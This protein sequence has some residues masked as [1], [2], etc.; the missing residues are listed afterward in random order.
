MAE[1]RPN[2]SPFLAGNYAPVAEEQTLT[3]L[4]VIGSIPES[5]DGRFIRNGPNPLDEPDPSTYHWFTGNG[6]V[7]GVR[8][9]DGRAE[10]Y[11]NRIVRGPAATEFL[12]EDP[13]PGPEHEMFRGGANTNV[14]GHAGATWAIVEAGGYPFRLNDELD[15]EAADPFGGTLDGP[16]T[17]HP[18]RDPDTGELH[19]I[20]Y[21]PF[22]GEIV[23]YVVVGVDG[24]VRKTVDVPVGG[25]PMVHDCGLTES[26]VIVLDL[27]CVFDMDLAM[28]GRFPFSWSD[29]YPARMG[30]LDR[31]AD[32]GN[33]VAWFDVDPCYV[34]HPLN[35]YDLPDGG[36]VLDAV[37]HPKV[38]ASNLNGPNEGGPTLRR[39]T[40]DPSSGKATEELLDDRP[41]EFPR[42]DERILGKPHRFGYGAA[43]IP[44]ETGVAHGDAV[45]HDLVGG[46]SE[47]HDYGEGRKTLEPVFVPTSDGS[48]ED[49]GYVMSYVY[50]ATTD[51][52]DIVILHAQDFTGEPVAT[53]KLPIRVP[54][55]FHGNWVPTGQ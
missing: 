4:E 43:F 23:H 46:T 2:P 1:L 51:T 24:K 15:T 41:Q 8:L 29:D 13:V 31:E 28:Q 20:C 21:S 53:V 54:Y 9:R 35:A 55:G 18:K 11:R 45:K 39:W 27:P 14:I 52:S 48:A 17:A 42:M 3:D 40:F 36:V 33:D 10:W 16:F 38:F 22:I 44:D 47:V 6:M 37:R 30:L 7:H 34:F 12:G 26:K 50:D 5:L 49:D 19:A 32:D 25:L